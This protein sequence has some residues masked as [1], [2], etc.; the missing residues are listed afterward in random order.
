[1][2]VATGFDLLKALGLRGDEGDATGA[3]VMTAHL[4]IVL[5]IGFVVSFI[6]ALGVVAWFMNWVRARGF[7]PFAIY[8][9]VAGIVLLVLVSQ[10]WR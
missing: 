10:G 1:M 3:V 8:R 2:V 9:I 5:V 4:W 6:V 7:I